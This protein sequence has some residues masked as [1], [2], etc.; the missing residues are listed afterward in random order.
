M[1]KFLRLALVVAVT[2]SIF[3]SIA[4]AKATSNTP[5]FNLDA[6]SSSG[7]TLS[8]SSVTGITELGNSFT[9]T[10]SSL[11]F[12]NYTQSFV[13][14]NSSINFGTS[15]KPDLTNGISIQFVA[16]ISN[17]WTSGSYPRLFDIGDSFGGND[18][19]V[20]ID[21]SGNLVFYMWK[22]GVSGSYICTTSASPIDTSNFVMYSF[23]IG[24]NGACTISVNG[25][26]VTSTNNNSTYSYS[27]RVFSTTNSTWYSRV[28][29][30][31]TNGA[32]SYLAGNLRNLVISAG[33]SSPNTVTFVPNGGSGYTASQ[34]N[35]ASAALN[36][37]QF[38]KSGG[39][40]NG[41]NTKSDGTGTSYSDRASF[42]FSSSIIL[43][44][45][46]SS[47]VTVTPTISSGTYVTGTSVPT[48]SY[49]ASPVITF[50]SNP[51]CSIYAVSD[52]SYLSPVTLNGSTPTGN[53]VAH[54]VGGVASGYTVLYGSD[55]SLTVSA[56]VMVLSSPS[57][58]KKLSNTN[59][60][61][62]LN[63]SGVF[64]FYESGIPIAHCIGISG[65]SPNLVCGW[66]PRRTG[67]VALWVRGTI[68]GSVFTS[69][70]VYTGVGNRTTP[71]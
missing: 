18:L 1:K 56:L 42:A 20:Q 67:G 10:P 69:N 27:T 13:F 61:L 62:T 51:T 22:S 57:G 66:K 24:S 47:N 65:S 33:S 17:N 25:S 54:C 55:A 16:K 48:V 43:Y 9:G 14:S 29:A 58:N 71:R 36:A 26:S 37:N 6:S 23:N 28:G 34:T 4:P 8:G 45:Q 53:Y 35:V 40:F 38:T 41:W 21:T 44:A 5:Y 59:L 32:Q 50:T 52:L 63:T 7:I 49:S 30:F 68:N 11:T 64:T 15:V 19:S 39:V 46:W 60:Q 12:D 3:S 31:I 70:V 2:S